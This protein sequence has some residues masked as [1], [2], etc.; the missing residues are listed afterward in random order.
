[1]GCLSIGYVFRRLKTEIDYYIDTHILR[2]YVSSKDIIPIPKLLEDSNKHEYHC[3]LIKYYMPKF[4]Y[5][6]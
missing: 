1:M 5:I 6:K 3:K 4:E 2:T